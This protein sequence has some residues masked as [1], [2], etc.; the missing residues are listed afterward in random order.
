MTLLSALEPRD[1]AVFE[2]FVVPRYLSIFGMLA[3]EMLVACEQ[4]LVA[5]V[6]CRT[7]FPDQLFATYLPGATVVGLDPSA[8][9]LE[10]ARTKGALVRDLSLE[11]REGDVP[12]AVAD[13]SFSH[14]LSLH[15]RL[16]APARALLASE[17]HRVLAPGGQALLAL[18]LRGSFQELMDLLREYALKFEAGGITSAIDAN[19]GTRPTLEGLAELLE[20]SGFDEVDIEVRPMTLPFKSGREFFEDPVSRLMIVPEIELSLGIGDL[21]APMNYVRDAIDKYWAEQEFELTVNV[22]CASA[23]RF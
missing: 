2:T 14:V 10:L 19:A 3:L 21:L 13:G 4:A 22:G 18:P 17:L 9:A 16:D 23:R 12:L 20:E 8:P 11:Y 5:H 15:P 6:G 7:G 1:V